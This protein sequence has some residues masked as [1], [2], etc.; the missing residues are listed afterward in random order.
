MRTILLTLIIVITFNTCGKNEPSESENKVIE[1]AVRTAEVIVE[2]EAAENE[3]A[4]HK[5]QIDWKIFY[6]SKR[7]K[8]NSELENLFK[9]IQEVKFFERMPDEKTSELARQLLHQCEN[10]KL[11]INITNADL[12]N[13]YKKAP[14]AY[15]PYNW[16]RLIAPT[17]ISLKN[18]MEKNKNLVKTNKFKGSRY[19]L[20]DAT[21][22][23]VSKQ[24]QSSPQQMERWKEDVESAMKSLPN[25]N[26][27]K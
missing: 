15:D 25:E 22:D 4:K 12:S 21:G 18:I 27:K 24:I 7:N 11:Y 6:E 16:E 8:L 20:D 5:N 23:A 2:I 1:L 13:F 26:I 9:I 17:I 19:F 14:P 10:I 3:F